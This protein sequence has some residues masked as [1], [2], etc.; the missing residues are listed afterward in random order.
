MMFYDERI[1]TECGKIYRRGILFAVIVTFLYAVFRA[2]NLFLTDEFVIRHFTTEIFIILCGIIILLW[3][4]IAFSGSHDERVEFEKHNFY[5][6][7]AKCFLI[8]TLAGYA[9]AIPFASERSTGDVPVN[10]IILL[11]EILGIMYF[12]YAFKSRDI[13][14]NYTFIEKRSGEYY[15]NVGLNILKLAGI[16][17]FP[18]GFAIVLDCLLHAPFSSLIVIL[19]SYIGSVLGLGAEYFLLSWVE[20]RSYEDE[21]GNLIDRGCFVVCIGMLIVY[22]FSSVVAIR[23]HYI[24][25][26]MDRNHPL[27]DSLPFGQVV[28]MLSN[29]QLVIGFL[30]SL[31]LVIAVS[32]IMSRSQSDRVKK[33]VAGYMIVRAV[34]ILFDVL[35]PFTVRIIEHIWQGQTENYYILLSISQIFSVCFTVASLLTV[36]FFS[37]AM[38]KDLGVHEIILL[39]PL[40]SAAWKIAE[41]FTTSSATFRFVGIIVGEILMLVY[42]VGFY[43][44]FKKYKKKTAI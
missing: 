25:F 32:Y 24:T 22:L 16:L 19:L 41:F 5:V 8:A 23:Q 9:F 30:F 18:F 15:A 27:F 11:L 21:S 42:Y 3:D 29:L 37:Y 39:M 10:Y 43:L 6:K 13:S 26:M 33:A 44:V 4:L 38:M 20:K 17:A 12:Y 35:W 31:V 34:G 36:F 2:V 14:F 7:A 1:H 40:M 28:A